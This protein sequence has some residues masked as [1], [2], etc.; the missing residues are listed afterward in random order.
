MGFVT[1]LADKFVDFLNNPETLKI[2]VSNRFLMIL[3]VICLLK[4]KYTTYSN[5]YLSALVNIPG[6]FLHE[7]SHFLV[8]LFLNAHPTR[9][10]LFPK[11]QGEYYLMGSVGF[12][13]VHFYNALPSALAPLL[14]LFVGYYFNRWFFTHIQINYINYVLYVFLQTIII[15]NSIPSSTDFKVAFS[16]PL[17][18]LF[19][20]A[21]FVIFLIYFI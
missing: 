16:Y 17:G 5:I 19:Y 20:S 15:E 14:L 2:F 11:K 12:R 8:G 3:L 10:N 7:M 21:V 1:I 4:M 9:F 6:T 13:N 18:V